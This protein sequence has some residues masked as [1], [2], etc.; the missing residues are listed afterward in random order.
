MI[1]I[2]PPPAPEVLAAE[3]RRREEARAERWPLA[4]ALIGT[5]LFHL[6][7][8]LG[9]EKFPFLGNRFDD[10]AADAQSLREKYEQ[11]EL[12]FLLADD[13]PPEAPKRF[14]EINPDAPENDPG[15]T[16]NF[17]ARNQQAA[18]PEPGTDHND[19]P[20]TSGEAEDSTAI[21]TGSRE[22]PVEAAP[23]SG[24]NGQN[25]TGM[26]A[27]IVG[28][29]A[30]P[31]ATEPL[32]GFEKLTGDNPDGIGTNIGSAPKGSAEDE[33]H[34]D[35]KN[36]GTTSGQ[37]MLAVSGGGLP[38]QPGRPSPKPRPK[39][40][41]VRPAV[42]ANQ[43]LSASN[44]GVIGV[45]A[46]FSEFGDYLQELIDT[47]DAQWQK[48][49]GDMTTYPPSRSVVTVR[50]KLTSQGEVEILDVVG[51]QTTGRVGT[52]TCLDAIRARAPY[53]PWTAEMV[54]VLGMEQEITFTFHYW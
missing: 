16:D 3:Q 54:R 27:V 25:G 8:Y 21:V 20:K 41:N 48:L 52:Y 50:F 44:A 7:A 2:L 35:G 53:R 34:Q 22:Q 31:K 42:L 23:L 43:P 36:D 49:V 33:K 39:L 9:A 4:I 5:I 46:K 51:E 11:Q 18:Q 37:Q 14:V 24:A 30:Q 40:Q 15:K 26:Q 19:R 45:D 6:L 1:E 13:A 29:P 28:D 47:V 10:V 17:G 32:P 12:T 38:G